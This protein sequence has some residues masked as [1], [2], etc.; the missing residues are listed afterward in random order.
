MA[1]GTPIGPADVGPSVTAEL[2]VAHTDH[3]ELMVVCDESGRI[4]RPVR[5]L[6]DRPR[7]PGRGLDQHRLA[8]RGD[9]V[10]AVAWVT[11]ASEPVLFA[12]VVL[13]GSRIHRGGG[14]AHARRATRRPACPV[15]RGIGVNQAIKHWCADMA[16][17]A[18]GAFAQACYAAV[19]VRDGLP[20]HG[21]RGADRQVPRR[22]GRSAE[23]RGR[24]SDPRCDGV[25][26]PE[27]TPHRYVYRAHLLGRC[28]A[29]RA[30]LLDRIVQR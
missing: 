26:E 4:A 6:H 17:S 8:G 14:R 9:G 2:S 24:R 13:R 27:A 28:L 1:L 25:H 19:A 22:R 20:G 3:A 29:S 21:H 12:G 5:R 7:R 18:E 10:D 16:V 11:A 30:N 23:Q 15:R